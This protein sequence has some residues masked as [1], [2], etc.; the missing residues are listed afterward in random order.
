M[1]E[2]GVPETGGGSLTAFWGG[3]T[4]VGMPRL[5]REEVLMRPWTAPIL[6]RG[7]Y[8]FSSLVKPKKKEKNYAVFYF[9]GKRK[10][11]FLYL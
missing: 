7:E 8:R 6:L 2:S 9:T 3:K 10:I 1:T 4:S 11:F 5:T